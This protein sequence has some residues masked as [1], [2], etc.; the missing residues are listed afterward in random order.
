[1]TG[2]TDTDRP[3]PHPEETAAPAAE[4]TRTPEQV[5]AAADPPPGA[6]PRTAAQRRRARRRRRSA[7]PL[8]RRLLSENLRRIVSGLACLLCGLAVVGSL[9][10]LTGVRGAADLEL[11]LFLVLL[12]VMLSSYSVIFAGLTLYALIGQPRSRL[13]AA[14]RLP[15]ARRQVRFYRW[16]VGQST[17][18]NEALQMLLIAMIAVLLLLSPPAGLPIAA[19]LA[20][21]AAAVVAAWIGA[22][23]SFAL[24][25]A[26]E[27]ADGRAFTLPGTTAAD[28]AIAE[29]LYGA[30]L[31]QSSSGAG[32]LTPLT[33]PARRLV[34]DHVVLAHVTTTIIITLGVSAV[35]TA[36]A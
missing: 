23:T 22:V 27:D 29:Y 16:S 15:R 33:A 34:R 11:A 14:A 17:A 12:I 9:R 5:P 7:Q 31:I 32:D 8:R 3:H 26:A 28:R 36:V 30:V 6:R 25:Y 4:A 10:L 21:T 24:E 1:M 18:L 20:L 13:I 35:I 19:L 2:A